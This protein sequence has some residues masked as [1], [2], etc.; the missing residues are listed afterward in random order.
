MSEPFNERI[1]DELSQKNSN[2]A[3][4]DAISALRERWQQEA[5]R[6]KPLL[7]AVKTNDLNKVEAAIAS[8]ISVDEDYTEDLLI[9][10]ACA[11]KPGESIEVFKYIY[12]GL[13]QKDP[14]DCL[15]RITTRNDVNNEAIKFLVAQGADI[16]AQIEAFN[17]PRRVNCNLCSSSRLAVVS[18]YWF[19]KVI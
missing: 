19:F 5:V 15:C 12:N 11:A 2:S 16:N 1:A 8:G 3:T 10:A 13:A 6:C 17:R 18:N 7:D 9:A 14:T 4:A